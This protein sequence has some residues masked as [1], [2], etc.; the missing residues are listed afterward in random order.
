MSKL[1][2]TFSVHS[3]LCILSYCIQYLFLVLTV[4]RVSNVSLAFEE[5]YLTLFSCY[6]TQLQLCQNGVESSLESGWCSGTEWESV[7]VFKQ[8]KF[9]SFNQFSKTFNTDEFCYDE[10]K[11]ADFVFMRWKVL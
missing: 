4:S 10:L 8:S 2:E 5:N 7:C 3:A 9:G 6:C 1:L 11:N